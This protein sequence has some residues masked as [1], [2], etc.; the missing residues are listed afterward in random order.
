MTHDIEDV[1]IVG[2]G[3]AGL[4]AALYTARDKL[5]TLIVEKY[6]PGGWRMALWIRGA[7]TVSQD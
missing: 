7:A 4:G 5:K 6:I 2:G 3:P 1:I